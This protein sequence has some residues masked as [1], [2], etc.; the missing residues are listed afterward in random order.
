MKYYIISDSQSLKE[1]SYVGKVGEINQFM[2]KT[3]HK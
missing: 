2:L 3:Q 1:T